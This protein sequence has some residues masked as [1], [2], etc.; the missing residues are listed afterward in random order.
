MTIWAWGIAQFP[1]L[2]PPNLTIF[3]ASAPAI[4]LQ[5]ITMALFLGALLLFPSFLYLFHIFKGDFLYR[6][7]KEKVL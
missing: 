1:Y 4:T 7:H 3:N 6:T 5:L 2:V